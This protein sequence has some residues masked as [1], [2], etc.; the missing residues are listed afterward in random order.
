M[1]KK[2]I[3][4]LRV[5]VAYTYYKLKPRA[6]IKSLGLTTFGKKKLEIS[7]KLQDKGQWSSTFWHEWLHAVAFEGGYD[8]ITEN[9]AFIE[10][11]SQAIMRMFT[12]PVG[13]ALLENMLLHLD[14]P[15]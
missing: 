14:P 2:E 4:S 5:P 10:Y 11:T 7:K 8:R 3:G 12:D 9:E 15:K 6:N 1:G 13:R